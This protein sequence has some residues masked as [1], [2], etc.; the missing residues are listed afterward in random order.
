MEVIRN[1]WEVTSDEAALL[2]LAGHSTRQEFEADRRRRAEDVVAWCSIKPTH[3]G[4]EIGSGEGTVASLLAGQC[5]SLDCN[6]ISASFLEMARA[7]CANHSNVRFHKIEAD[8]LDHLPTDTYDFGF[9][10]NVFIHFNAYDIFNYLQSVKRILKRGGLFYFDAC[11]IGEQ[12]MAL[13]REQ[14]EMYRRAP[15]KLRGLLNYN[16]PDMLRTIIHEAGLEL[17]PRSEVSEKGWNKILTVK[18]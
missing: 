7:K 3:N 12:T 14:A 10:L 15:E 2:A 8:Y 13:F 16:H 17:S 18:R 4:F 6:D 11:T 5:L 1:A 9:S